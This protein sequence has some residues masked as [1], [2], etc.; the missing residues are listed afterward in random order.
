MQ[1][2]PPILTP[3]ET[4]P[5]RGRLGLVALDVRG[6]HHPRTPRGGAIVLT[7]YD[8]VTHLAA[9][10]RAIWIGARRSVYLLPLKAFADQTAPDRFVR[11]VL[12]RIAGRPGGAAQ[13]AR[14]AEIESRGRAPSPTRATW[15]LVIACLV[16]FALQL[17]LGQ[18]M[19][20][21][22]FYNA[23]LVRDGDWWRL[24]TAN[25][26]HAFPKV[27]IHLVLNLLGLIALGTL[28]ERPLGAARTLVVMG[29][30][31]LA[32]MGASGLAGYPDV[33]GVSGVVFGLFGAVTWLELRR[34]SDMPAWWRIPRRAIY[35]MLLLS[36]AIGVLVPMIAGAAHLGGFL[37]GVAVTALI[38]RPGWSLPSTWVRLAAG[39]VVAVS[40]LA[41][42]AAGV[43]LGRPGDY[44]TRLAARLA[45]LPGVPPMDLN[46]RAW[47]IAVDPDSSP[48]LLEAALAMAERA[49]DETQRKEPSVLDTLAELQFQLGHAK[50]AVAIIDEAILEA[51]GERYYQEQRRRFLGER[52]R[53]DR[54]APPGVPE[55][56]KSETTTPGKDPGITV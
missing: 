55:E 48:Q 9:S 41:S 39:A 30:S 51:P 15:G 33:V 2:E 26:L 37:A 52:G 14:M 46:N 18:E 49:V 54:P 45:K 19:H 43:E 1:P 5:L 34:A 21:V 11:G 47:M 28:A 25:L 23:A 29:V 27:P 36:L 56:P 35:L 31:G 38:L 16:V 42:L 10:Q 17:S 22:G 53:D 44:T 40:A 4:F 13:L 12:E 32:A 3:P 8:E 20:D 6:I 24:V 50:Q 7:P